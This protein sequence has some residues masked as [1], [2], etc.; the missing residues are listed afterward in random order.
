MTQA[1]DP[2]GYRPWQDPSGQGGQPGGYGQPPGYGGFPGGQ[3]GGYPQQGG[4]PQP[5]GY[6]QPPTGA[7]PAGYQPYGG[8][9]PGT[10]AYYPT[11]QRRPGSIT[12]AATL[13]FVQSGFV[14]ISGIV[15]LA[16]GSVIIDQFDGELTGIGVELTVVAVVTLICGALLIAGGAQVFQRRTVLLVV[17]CLLSLVLSV[18]WFI[19]TISVG[20]D[21]GS[22]LV[23]PIVFAIMPIVALSLVN[24][25]TAKAWLGKRPAA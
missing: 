24:S 14:I 20:G 7:A 21:V 11:P 22:A 25:T 17:A 19:R 4:Y 3:P 8:Y 6:E 16:G 2:S 15:L 9:P 13:S 23:W 12:G 5:G 1:G 18:Y 10:G